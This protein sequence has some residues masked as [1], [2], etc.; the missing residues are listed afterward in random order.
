YVKDYQADPMTGEILHLDLFR[1]TKDERIRTHVKIE[2]TGTAKGIKL[3]GIL[4][5]DMRELEVECLP[6]DL[7]EKIQ[8]NVTD[9]DIGDSIHVKDV[10]LGDAV[11]ITSIPEASIASVH[12]PKVAA[13]EEKVE[14]AVAAEGEGEEAK[15]A[16]EGGEKSVEK[17]T[18]EK[19]KK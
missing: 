14:E 9:L 7:P 4:E 15:K 12:V 16:E 13:V 8:I 3:G 11:K 18:K 1:V 5:V 19:D 10:N 2:F 6:M 17:D